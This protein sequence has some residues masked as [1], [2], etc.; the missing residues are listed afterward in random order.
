MRWL[1]IVMLTMWLVGCGGSDYTTDG[2][3]MDYNSPEQNSTENNASIQPIKD[4]YFYTQWYLDRNDSFYEQNDIDINASI[5]FDVSSPLRGRGVT[6]AIIDDGLDTTHPDLNGSIVA[7]FD[8][9][10]GGTNVSPTNR[11]DYHG[12]AVTGIIAADRNTI[13]ITG[14][15]SQSRIVFLKHKEGMSDSDTIELFMKAKELGADIVNCSWGTYD[16]SDAVKDV[17]ID[18]AIHGRDGKGMVIVFAAGNDDRDMGNDESA[19]PEVIAVGSTDRGNL[20]AWYSNYGKNLDIVAPGGYEVGIST[21][22]PSGENG[23]AEINEDYLLANDANA[24]V[25]TSAS[26]P[27]VT[28]VIAL[29]LEKNPDLTR[30]EIEEILH[31]SSD[32]IGSLDYINGFNEYYGYGKVNAR[33]ILNTVR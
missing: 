19:I 5:H 3:N 20:R 23:I 28:G 2:N 15:A 21:L 33:K 18:L 30:K 25:G 13:G 10:S 14:I 8:V 29:M 24:F 9:E 12:T 11:Y 7:T 22:D 26:A 17:I 16:V 31:N 27:I 6:I 4:P 1:I 32:E